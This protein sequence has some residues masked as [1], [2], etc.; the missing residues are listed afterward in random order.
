M[1]SDASTP[2]ANEILKTG[3][4]NLAG[5]IAS[6][7]ANP[8]LVRFSEDD[9]QFLKFHGIY[10]QDDRDLRKTGK[11]YSMLIRIRVPGGVLTPDQYLELDRLSGLYANGTLRITSRQTI[12]FHGVLKSR[13]GNTIRGIHET[14]L[15]TLATCGDVVRNITAPSSPEAGAFGAEMLEQSNQL[16]EFFSP[17]T[18]S[19]HNIW[20]DGTAIDLNEELIDPIYNKTYLPR[21]FKIAFALPP[22]NDTDVFTNDIGLIGIVENGQLVGYNLTAGGGMGRSHGNAAT[23]PRLADL[24]GFITPQ[25]VKPALLA[26]VTIHR[27]FG[28]RSN[29]KH[30]RLKYVLAER[31]P[32]WFR[33]ELE[34]RAEIQIQAARPSLFTSQ[35][36]PLDWHIQPDNRL[37][38]GLFI[39]TGRIKDDEI[40]KTRTALRTL[41]TQYRPE[42]R[43]TPGNNLILA[44]IDPK[45]RAGIDAIL[46]NH[47]VHSA[48]SFTASRRASTACV[49]LPTCGLA[50]AEA[51]RAFPGLMTQIENVLKETGLEGEEIILRV[52]GCPNGCARPY[53]AEIGLVGKA[54]GKYQLY[55]GG[56]VSGTRLAKLW[57][58]PV[59]EEDLANEWR[60]LFAQFAAQREIGERF[61]DWSVRTL[62]FPI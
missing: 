26:A 18:P 2:S 16:A 34:R 44:N 45:D 35:A 10:Q 21:K 58:D 37:L 55:L 29:R 62:E 4:P 57:K 19:Y 47:G 24:I 27:D 12:Q 22:V 23:F 42:V 60:V 49:S 31:G 39:E 40:R 15:T 25:Q 33:A 48:S 5:T 17:V 32:D 14:L 9:T 53:M 38:L 51:E 46:A 50:L 11:Q 56:N 30:A 7:L 20:I 28:D 13:L 1:N 54:P 3:C 41:I 61:G 36:D 43:L 59:K 6:T 8:D 52:T